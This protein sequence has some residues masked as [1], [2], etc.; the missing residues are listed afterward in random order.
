MGKD[1]DGLNHL[2]VHLMFDFHEHQRQMNGQQ[3]GACKKQD[4]QEYRVRKHSAHSVIVEQKLEIL[5]THPGTS[6]DSFLI[7]E[8]FEGDQNPVHGIIAEDKYPDD[9]RNRHQVQQSVFPQLL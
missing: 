4:I 2:V 8:A 1:G 7:A 3:R 6:P 9:G 5:Q